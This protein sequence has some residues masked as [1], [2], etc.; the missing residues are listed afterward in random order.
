VSA[1]TTHVLDLAKGTPAAGVAV[2][3]EI[4]VELREP[5]EMWKTLAERT[6]D[7]DGR[8]RDFIAAGSRLDVG[9]YRLTFST[10]EYFA[11][12]RI[13]SFHPHV[14]VEFEVRDAAQHHH[15]PLLLS[16]FGYSTYR[17]S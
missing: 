8:V 17:G 2:V 7:A 14:M 4:R 6:T 13:A 5:S 16:P 12:Q 9:R 10:G 11:A 15:V 1:I 3:L